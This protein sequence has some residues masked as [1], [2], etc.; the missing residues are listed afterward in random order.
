M[1]SRRSG[2]GGPDAAS[3]SQRRADQHD[4]DDHQQP[5]DPVDDE[6]R[7]ARIPTPADRRE[8]GDG[9]GRQP[10]EERMGKHRQEGDEEQGPAG[11]AARPGAARPQTVEQPENRD[12]RRGEERPGEHAVERPAMEFDAVDRKGE[13]REHVDV[14]RVGAEQAGGH[15]EARAA[16][17]PHLAEQ[18]AG[19]RVGDIV[20]SGRADQSL[21]GSFS[22]CQVW[23]LRDERLEV[24]RL[25]RRGGRVL[26]DHRAFERRRADPRK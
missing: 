4:A 5:I 9:V 6:D 22:T 23:P 10:V 25:A 19:Q 18:R 20:Q 14:G 3:R 7:V 21:C 26:L 13:R 11:T 16:L 17:K 12:D 1:S 2:P 24:G 8:Q 15:G